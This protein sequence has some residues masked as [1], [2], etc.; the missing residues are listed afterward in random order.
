M[1]SIIKTAIIPAAIIKLLTSSVSSAIPVNLYVTP[2]PRSADLNQL[3]ISITFSETLD[4]SIVA[5]PICWVNFPS[6]LLTDCLFSFGMTDIKELTGTRPSR[7]V[8]FKFCI[9]VIVLSDSG[10]LALISTSS[11][12]SSGLYS[13]T[14]NPPF[15]WWIWF[16]WGYIFKTRNFSPHISFNYI[17]SIIYIIFR[18][19]IQI[20]LNWIIERWPS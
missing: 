16:R 8:T 17:S 3:S 12:A 15:H 10:N 9:P 13:P 2:F 6:L 11:L 18:C 7:V 19:S 14:L 5:A 1:S 20:K 4:S